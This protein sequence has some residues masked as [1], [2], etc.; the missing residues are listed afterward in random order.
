MPCFA[1]GVKIGVYLYIILSWFFLIAYIGFLVEQFSINKWWLMLLVV[2]IIHLLVAAIYIMVAEKDCVPDKSGK[3]II[4]WP[5]VV[6]S[7]INLIPVGIYVIRMIASMP[8]QL[9]R[10]SARVRPQV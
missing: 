9:P 6:Q 1:D 3:E 10:A 5:F 4:W 7:I 8:A 2:S